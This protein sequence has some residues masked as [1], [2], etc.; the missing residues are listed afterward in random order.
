MPVI[1]QHQRRIWFAL[2][3][4]NLRLRSILGLKNYKTKV[5][6]FLLDRTNADSQKFCRTGMRL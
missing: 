1:I 2:L 6:W 3:D 5:L 4:R